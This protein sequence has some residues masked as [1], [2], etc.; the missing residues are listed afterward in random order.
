[1]PENEI[2]LNFKCPTCGAAP[3]EK[4]DLNSGSPH[5]QSHIERWNLAKERLWNRLTAK[6]KLA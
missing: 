4:C 2:P 6:S 1:M 3:Q 5:F